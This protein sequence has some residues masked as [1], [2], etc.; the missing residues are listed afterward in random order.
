MDRANDVGGEVRDSKSV[1][2][3]RQRRRA[4]WQPADSADAANLDATVAVSSSNR[5]GAIAGQQGLA[6]AGVDVAR[7]KQARQ[8]GRPKPLKLN[9]PSMQQV[10]INLPKRGLRDADDGHN[11]RTHGEGKGNSLYQAVM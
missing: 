9:P 4:D 3:E 1:G 10:D 11:P 8:H 6:G 2:M 7:L 5:A